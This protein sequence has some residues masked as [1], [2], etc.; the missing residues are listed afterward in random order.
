[1]KKAKAGKRKEKIIK[2]KKQSNNHVLRISNIFLTF[3]S[4]YKT[5]AHDKENYKIII[6]SKAKKKKEKKNYKY[7]CI[8]YVYVFSDL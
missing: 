1:M 3:L 2:K 6:K 4:E 7:V 5:F 8:V